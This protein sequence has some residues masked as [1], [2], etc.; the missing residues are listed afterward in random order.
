MTTHDLAHRSAR[1]TAAG[2]LLAALAWPAV[3]QTPNPSFALI[4]HIEQLQLDQP[5]NALSGGKVRVKGVEVTLLRNLLLTMPGQYLTLNDLFRGPHPGTAPALAPVRPQSGLA[6]ADTPAPRVPFEINVIG[7]IVNGEYIAAVAR[8]F[9]VELG[10]G[11]G[12][13][14]AIDLAK[15]E[16]LVGARPEAGES[17]AAKAARDAAAARVRLNDPEGA[18]GKRNADKFGGGASPLDD[19]FSVDPENPPVVAL[20]GFPMCIPRSAADPQCPA[21]NRAPAPDATR[22]TCGPTRAEASSPAH[23]GCNPALKAPVLVGDYVSYAGNLVPQPGMPG[24]FFIG[25]HALGVQAGIY[26]SPGANPA[27]VYI[28][29]GLMGMLGQP[30]PGVDQE[31]TSRFR[32]VGFTTDP[33]RSVD[34]FLV[35]VAPDGSTRERR[36]STLAPEQA[37]QIGRVRITLPSK[38]N[39]LAVTREMRLRVAGQPEGRS[40]YTAPIAEYIYPEPTRFGQ[41]GAA[42]ALPVPVENFCVLAKGGEPLATL[43]R[44]GGPALGPLDPYPDSG[45]PTAQPRADGSPSCPL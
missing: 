22:F 39:F 20:T 25:A 9:Q 44:S 12:F 18:Y 24:R 28:E 26:T 1:R 42:F 40:E 19:R 34:V 21:S 6:L 15:G 27:H 43:G 4:G 30:F 10:I 45:H 5:G 23:P 3:A 7:N 37:G 16:L 11:A 29:E 41:R 33:S 17:P 36:L 32:T 31:E 2:A 38:A 13:V 14:R 35:D 8:I